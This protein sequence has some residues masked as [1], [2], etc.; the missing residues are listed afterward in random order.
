MAD[1]QNLTK[2]Y[3]ETATGLNIRLA[4]VEIVIID[5]I[6]IGTADYEGSKAFFTKA[7]APLGI[8]IIM[9]YEP[10]VGFGKAGK[11]EFWLRR[12]AN[13]QDPIHVAFFAE[14]RS[15][16]DAF[17]EAAL[18]AGGKDNG[19]PGIRERYHPDYYGAFVLDLDG[20]NIEAACHKPAT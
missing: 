8:E 15:Q 3:I 10:W 2:Q 4:K 7:L 1:Y 14:N 13:K 5:H 12:Q 9:E 6:G 19:A 17:Y 18:A 11:A 16:V 20:N